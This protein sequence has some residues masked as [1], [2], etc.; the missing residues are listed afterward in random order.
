MCLSLNVCLV[1]AAS[2]ETA[3]QALCALTDTPPLVIICPV[4]P[5]PSINHQSVSGCV[6]RLFAPSPTISAAMAPGLGINCNGGETLACERPVEVKSV[7]LDTVAL[8]VAHQLHQQQARRS[9]DT[10]VTTRAERETEAE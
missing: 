6:H 9:I 1:V 10:K 7:G 4:H 2:E 8:G 5:S 3:R